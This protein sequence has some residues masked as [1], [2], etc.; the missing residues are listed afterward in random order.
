ML[1]RRI[2]HLEIPGSRTLR[3][4]IAPTVIAANQI[5]G[6]VRQMNMGGV[7]VLRAS[8]NL[9]YNFHVDAS[10]DDARPRPAFKIA[11]I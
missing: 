4:E 5:W 10:I 11:C 9:G 2:K 6:G 3:A 8:I 7:R 1:K